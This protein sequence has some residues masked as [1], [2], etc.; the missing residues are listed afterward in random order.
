M[1]IW[2]S[3][4]LLGK[5]YCVPSRREDWPVSMFTLLPGA[6][7]NN[8]HRVDPLALWTFREEKTVVRKT[9]LRVMLVRI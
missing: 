3:I 4:I 2:P 5:L 7:Y 6:D 9:D 1:T 8:L